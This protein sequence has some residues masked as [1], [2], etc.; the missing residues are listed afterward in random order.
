MTCC[1][2]KTCDVLGDV[3]GPEYM[4]HRRL[5][6]IYSRHP[7]G[8]RIVTA[9]VSTLSGLLKPFLVPI[10]AAVGL[11]ILPIIAAAKFKGDRE[12]AKGHLK[13]WGFCFLTIGAT[14]AF[15]SL[16]TFYMP[17]VWSSAVVAS[18]CALSIILH[19]Y[20]AM[21]EPDAYQA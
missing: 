5:G 16:T 2:G 21:K 12:S 20:K 13:A 11:L 1:S 7:V 10:I 19:V 18:I 6:G 15:F 14:V 3:F 17:L 8:A 9:N 4:V